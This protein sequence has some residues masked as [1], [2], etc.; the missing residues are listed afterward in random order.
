MVGNLLVFFVFFIVDD[1]VDG[2]RVEYSIK[3]LGGGFGFGVRDFGY[4]WGFISSGWY[5]E[6]DD[7]WLGGNWLMLCVEGMIGL[8]FGW[9]GSVKMECVGRL[10]LRWGWIEVIRWCCRL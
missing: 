6:C 10:R 1:K 3:F 9:E 4:D 5:C 7:M 2:M 8:E